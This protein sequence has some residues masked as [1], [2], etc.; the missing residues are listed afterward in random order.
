MAVQPRGR[1]TGR[2]AAASD[3]KAAAAARAKQR[4]REQQQENQGR[5]YLKLPAN[6]KMLEYKDGA[7]TLLSV[8]PYIVEE[9]HHPDKVEPGE[10]WYKRP[11][12]VHRSIGAGDD[13]K[14]YVCPRTF[15]PRNKC[16]ICENVAELSKNW[17]ANQEQIREEK[18][19]NRD[20]MLVYNHD[21]K[22]LCLINEPYGGGN[23][24]GFGMLLNSRIENPRAEE[25][26]AFWLDGEDGMALDIQWKGAGLGGKKDWIKPISIDFVARKDAPV[27][28][29]IWG[30]AIELSSLLIKTEPAA[31]E[32]A[33]YEIP[34]EDIVPPNDQQ[35]PESEQEPEGGEEDDI[36]FDELSVAEQVEAMKAWSKEELLEFSKKAELKDAKG[37]D[38]H[39]FYARSDIKFVYGAVSGAWVLLFGDNDAPTEDEAGSTECP[40]GHPFGAQG[41]NEFDEC[42]TCPE[43]SYEACMEAAE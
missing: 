16:A 38:I 32:A 20:L 3:R 4:A 23:M 9:K 19:K 1:T 33:Y 15:N 31:L 41:F 43:T 12:K 40:F 35:G 8:I 7:R 27:P 37:K 13:R 22:E 28:K 34:E 42:K 11:F 6:I 5:G 17:D 39:K 25:W 26:A 30:R 29:D 2:P 18:A 21:S 14:D 36:P 24:V 10:L